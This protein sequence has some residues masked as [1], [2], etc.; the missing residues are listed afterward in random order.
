MQSLLINNESSQSQI[1]PTNLQNIPNLANYQV[2][3][4]SN[5][6]LNK[7]N[8]TPCVKVVIPKGKCCDPSNILHI[9]T[10]SAIN[11]DLIND[12]NENFLF[13]V[14]IK[15]PV[16]VCDDL[17]VKCNTGMDENSANDYFCQ[18]RIRG[19]PYCEQCSNNCC[20]NYNDIHLK[21]MTFEIAPSKLEINQDNNE[22]P[23]G[24]IQRF[25]KYGNSYNVRQFYD[26][27]NNLRYQIGLD[28]GCKCDCSGSCICNCSGS[29]NC[30]CS[31]S[32]NC[33]SCDDCCGKKR[34]L[35]KKIFDKDLVECGEYN[36]VIKSG[37]CDSD[38]YLE[39]RFPNNTNVPMKLFLLG[40]L[41]DAMI[42]PYL[43]TPEVKTPNSSNFII[44]NNFWFIYL[45][46]IIVFLILYA[47]MMIDILSVH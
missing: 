17:E 36:I 28:E 14:E 27:Q 10:L 3:G 13:K 20:C 43:S 1:A 31:G 6:V 12:V 11:Q 32:G 25:V 18:F 15:F 42:I 8:S 30:N 41:I 40:G 23:L 29:G 16:T 7:L 4:Y 24:S 45:I 9:Y 22:I 21:P 26:I 33:C 19:T 46:V 35:F 34:F 39:I 38:V 37:C 5:N 2:N 47:I 44:P